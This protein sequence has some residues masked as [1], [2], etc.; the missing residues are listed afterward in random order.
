MR[1]WPS[2]IAGNVANQTNMG[3]HA[4]S[5]AAMVYCTKYVTHK[6]FRA[7]THHIAELAL[8][9]FT[10]VVTNSIMLQTRPWLNDMH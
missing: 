3:S 8:Y 2:K 9:Y 1:L 5:T 6:H 10:V 4:L 7:T